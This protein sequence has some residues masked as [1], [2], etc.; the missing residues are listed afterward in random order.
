MHGQLIIGTFE[1]FT[2]APPLPPSN[3]TNG[4]DGVVVASSGVPLV[5]PSVVATVLRS[6]RVARACVGSLTLHL[7]AATP[8]NL[9]SIFI[10]IS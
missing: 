5:V 3:L 9:Q 7:T 2:I 1:I 4:V 10:S 6:A 8:S